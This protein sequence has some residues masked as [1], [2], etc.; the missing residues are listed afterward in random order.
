MFVREWRNWQTRTFEGRVVY[1]Y[2]FK[3]RLS[4][5]TKKQRVVAAFLF[6]ANEARFAHEDA[7]LMKQPSAMKCGFAT[8]KVSA[9]RF[10]AD[11]QLH[12]SV[13]SASLF[14]VFSFFSADTLDKYGKK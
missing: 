3:S 8:I 14:A 5:Q 13:A 4:H 11:T 1:P 9:L 12:V 2:G 6:G 10:M 7:A